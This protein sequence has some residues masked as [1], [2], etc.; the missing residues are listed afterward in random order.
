MPTYTDKY[1]L[2]RIFCTVVHFQS[3][4]KA[5]TFLRLPVSSVSKYVKQLEAQLS[6]QLIIR[7]TRSMQLTDMG[8]IYYQ[9]GQKILKQVEDLDEEIL[10]LTQRANGL[11]RIS[12]PLMLGEQL[13][14]PL[15][16]EF[17]KLHPDI[18]LTL[19]FSHTPMD[20]IEQD[21]DIAFRTAA[22]LPDSGLFELKLVTLQSIY[23]ASPDYLSR[24][25][26]PS[27]M[28]DLAK[29][30]RLMF[31]TD[32]HQPHQKQEQQTRRMVSNSYQSLITAA[33]AGCGI[34]CVYDVFVDKALST[35][36][37]EQVLTAQ[38][39]DKKYLSMLYRQRADTSMKIQTFI[40]FIRQRVNR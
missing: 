27:D 3:F 26:K 40:D 29:H 8:D 10:S 20:L 16:T 12:M 21:F 11:L 35:G 36:E 31:Q 9:K 25:G 13:L 30:Q 34:A 2:L 5:A 32:I 22:H 28:G 19:D 4:S 23:V 37:L 17:A 38:K 14:T 33:K 15:L 18:Q 39:P 7:N 24:Y 6:A 1:H